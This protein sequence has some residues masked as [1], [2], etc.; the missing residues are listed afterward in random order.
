MP[1][2]FLSE[3]DHERLSTC[4]DA[5]AQ[6]D[7][8]TY[9]LLNTE[10]LSAVGR[11]RGDTN[12]LGF[13]LQLCC[14][15]YLGFF[16]ANLRT[17][18]RQIVGYVGHQLSLGSECLSEYGRREAT[19][20]EHQQQVLVHLNYRRATPVDLLALED[21]LLER[22]LEHDRP[23]HIFDLTSDYLRRER[24]VRPGATRLAQLMGQARSRAQ[25]VAYER[26]QP[27]LTRERRAFLDSLLE[28]GASGR[29]YLVWLQRTP[30]SNQTSAIMRT[31]DKIAFLQK[32]DVGEWDLSLLNPN[33]RK[34]L[35]KK[36]SRARADNLSH[37][38][39]QVRYPQLAA[40][41]EEAL[42]TFTDALLDMLDARLW[43]LHGECRNEFKQDR[44]AATK[45]INE[46]MRVLGV[47]GRL[48]LGDL[49]DSMPKESGSAGTKLSENE[50]R[51]ALK[52]AEHLTRPEDD[53]YVDYFAKKH[54]QVQNFSKRLLEVMTFHRNSGDGGLLEGLELINEIHAGVR[55]K[56]PMDAPTGFI[57][58]VWE[59]EVFGENGVD[60][61]SYEIAALWVLREKLR[62]GDVYVEHSRRYLQLERYLIPRASWQQE[63]KDAMGLLG[64]PLSA[65]TRLTERKAVFKELATKLDALLGDGNG[66]THTEEGRIVVSPL[67]ADEEPPSLVRLRK[68][69][70]DRLPRVDITDVLIAVDN[71]TGFSDA[72]HHLDG[73]ATR[74]KGLLMQLYACLLA[75]ACNLGF[76][77]MAISAELPYQTLLWCN[78]WYLRDETLDE[79]VTTLVNYH[80]SLPL[81]SLWGGGV[82]S[83]SDGQRFPVSGN[84]RK[85]RALPRYFGYGKG[86]TAY[87]W[88]SDQLS[89]FGNKI[90]PSTL[91]DATYVLDAI[92]DNETDLDIAEHTTDT[93]GYTELIFGLFG[94]LGLTFS[95]RIKDLADQQLYR[96]VGFELGDFDLLRPHLN[97]VLGEA[98][99]TGGWDEMLRVALSLKKGYCTASLL[100]SKLQVYPRQ[101]PITRAL[102]E[103]GRLE[104]TIHILRWYADPATRKRVS[105]QLNKGEA[106]HWL[107]K[108]IMFGGYGEVSGK[109]DEALDQQFACLNLV[110]NAVVVFNTIHIARIAEELKREGVEVR[111]EDLAR[112]WPARFAHI[113][114]LGKYV[115]D[116]VKMRNP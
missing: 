22:A 79:A 90:I 47:L 97:K 16:P 33:R 40:F 42:Y 53:A 49:P 91:R 86:V 58:T 65:H 35:A 3:A 6:D 1:I 41:A 113:N 28:V 37:L 105:K 110:A 4:P 64:A 88:T 101:H 92:L 106:L 59:P 55:R 7:L 60:W 23:K 36:S 95:P 69:I 32:H 45:T 5:L 115:F 61:R 71:L 104:K 62:S 57:P 103:Y 12:R 67:E 109:E 21:W 73:V 24:I 94:L 25:A 80:H 76:K 96:P 102:Q 9:F 72:F 99:I 112:V 68:L 52:N 2:Q 34:W 56:L 13:A 98:T 30:Q 46:T 11:L 111:D 78:R 93:S 44:L 70:D 83:S 89:Q 63:R 114:F 51:L 27:F 19:F 75:Q 8:D 38:Q 100:I 43:E 108:T 74:G 14:L 18:D 81:S 50:V 107:R 26:L 116:E 15:R 82:L 10:D 48:Y 84:T 77:Q 29:T 17:L 31:L 39:D 87:S 85:A 66:T 54:R 20:H